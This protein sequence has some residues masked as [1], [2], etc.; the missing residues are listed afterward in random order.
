MLTQQLFRRDLVVATNDVHESAGELRSTGGDPHF[1]LKPAEPLR[2]GWYAIS[3]SGTLQQA[4]K[5]YFDLGRGFNEQHAARLSPA[6]DQHC[7]M[8][9]L[10]KPALL[11]RLDPQ[12]TAG[13]FKIDRL[14][15]RRL[16]LA[17]LGLRR[18]QHLAI[19]TVKRPFVAK[20]NGHAHS[21]M[22]T[23]GFVCL[24]PRGGD[25]HF[26]TPYDAWIDAYD[27]HPT[28]HR[29]T[30]AAQV[31]MLASTPTISVLMPVYNT[32]ANLLEAAIQSVVDQVYPHWELCIADDCSTAPHVRP[33]LEA[34]QRKEPNRIKLALRETNGHIAHATN[35]AFALATG[36][37]I[38]LLDHDDILRENALA[39]VALTLA[40]HPL[41]ELV[42]SDE[43]K[44]DSRGRRFDV[45]FKC[46]YS[47]EL[48]RSMNYFN[49]LTVHRAANIRAVGGWRP[50]FEGSQDYDINLRILERINAGG[51]VH[52]PKVLYHW[53]AVE[54]STALAGGEKSY[55][56]TAGWK[57]LEEHVARTGLDAEVCEVPNV[58]F[59]RVKHRVA[60]P[61]PLVS[62]I[63]PTKDKADFLRTCL[64]SI[65]EKTTYR[66]Y[67]I[68]VVDNNSEEEETL[69][70][71]KEMA[72]DDRVRVMPYPHAFNYSGINNAAVRL[73]RGSIVGLVNNDIEVISPDWLTEM[74]SWV[75]QPAIG[76][77]GAK[78]L[79]PDDT[80]Q[81][82]GVILGIGGVANH[83]HRLKHRNDPSYFGRAVV[84][85]TLSAVTAACLLVR[86]AVYTQVRGLD[87]EW[88]KVAFNDV[89]FCLKV[90]NAGYRNVWTPFAELY[91]HESKS[92]GMEDTPEKLARF[93]GEVHT[94]MERWQG[95]LANDPFYSF[96][97]TR[98]MDDFAIKR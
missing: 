1:V 59:Y 26:E 13:A 38:A 27:Y 19:E 78:L 28:R 92:R 36:D 10:H 74:V 50:G 39:E 49:H 37:W 17:E 7:A 18:A 16:T 66:N 56:F 51:V 20:A 47:P 70:Y 93:H 89:D 88:L 30:L 65:R 9:R 3:L 6:G 21:I 48:F 91:H 85:Q 67:E 31:A 64:D 14:A 97:L 54:G 2:R 12:E 29:G 4:A 33:I 98:E 43:D 45:H 71:L 82:A 46:D 8:V 73:A 5:L 68:I 57:A 22:T 63:I 40:E 23:R 90:R 11:V 42:Y 62:L 83:A 69:A 25:K 72:R 79:Y 80:V 58:P 32:P 24:S 34:W 76:C 84:A 61:E 15:I 87:S 44:I 95:D 77:V 75:Q 81:H 35:S 86:K 52:I 55:A 96:N 53:R 60:A 94:M 41:A